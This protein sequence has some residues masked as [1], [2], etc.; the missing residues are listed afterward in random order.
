VRQRAA[1]RP[2]RAPG[3]RLALRVEH[4]HEIEVG[5]DVQLAAAALAHRDDEQLL[6]RALG[7]E[8]HA[9]A[10]R[11][12]IGQDRQQPLHREL[13]KG[14]HRAHH[15]RQ[16]SAAGGIAQGQ[17]RQQPPAQAAQRHGD[18]GLATG[19]TQLDVELMNQTHRVPGLR[20]LRHEP[21]RRLRAVAGGLRHALCVGAGRQHAR[22]PGLQRFDRFGGRR[23]RKSGV[24]HADRA[25]LDRARAL[26]G[27]PGF[28]K[29][30][31]GRGLVRTGPLERTPM[32][33]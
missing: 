6:R 31:A 8:R 24:S 30:A 17:R 21:G 11:K 29:V 25:A 16:R 26:P 2:Q 5:R 4:E 33:G 22:R 23:R 15:F 14:R 3:S 19:S 1:R 32:L 28:F 13:G 27:R 20:G 10:L 7:P 18:G 9:E 12:L